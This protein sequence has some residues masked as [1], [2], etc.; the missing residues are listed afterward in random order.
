MIRTMGLRREGRNV[1]DDL[2]IGVA[3]ACAV[4]SGGQ[5]VGS[6]DVSNTA[7]ATVLVGTVVSSLLARLLRGR[8]YARAD[9]VLYLLLGLGAFFGARSLN[10]VFPLDTF[11]RELQPSSWLIWM[12]MFGSFVTWRDVTLLFQA[13]PALALFG[14]VGCYDTFRP[15]VFFFF[16]YLICIATLFARTH[17]R[18]M[19]ERAE[20]SGYFGADLPN[21]RASN[22]VTA[23]LRRGPWRWAAGPEWALGS[24]FAIV[25]V[26]LLGAPAVRQGVKPISGVA[27][28]NVTPTRRSS[29]SAVSGAP[30]TPQ[31][32][33]RIAQGPVRL[34]NTPAFD[35]T[36]SDE[37]YF[38]T[39]GFDQYRTGIW[40]KVWVWTDA[41]GN[42]AA[43]YPRR[44]GRSFTAG[45]GERLSFPDRDAGR[46]ASSPRE[47][48]AS[49]ER[50]ERG[51]RRMFVT[52]REAT[53]S[54]PVPGEYLDIEGPV[55]NRRDP[56]GGVA[57]AEARAYERLGVLYSPTPVVGRDATAGT[58]TAEETG[59]LQDPALSLEDAPPSV[60]AFA[61][62]AAGN[63]PDGARAERLRAAIAARIA[64]NIN[65]EAPPA[66]RDPVENA[67]FTT[68]EG[69]CDVFASAMVLG[70]RSLGI[71]A[72][73]ATGYV[74]DARNVASD[75][76]LVLLDSDS[77]AWAELYFAGI[78]WVPFDATAGARVVPGGDR[79]SGDPENRAFADLPIGTLVN[80]AIGALIV[81]GAALLLWPRR[82]T[83]RTEARARDLLVIRYVRALER[84]TRRTRRRD[85]TLG[86]FT[87]SAELGVT[88]DEA[89]AIAR[90]LERMLYAPPPAQAGPPDPGAVAALEKRVQSLRRELR[91]PSQPAR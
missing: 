47:E 75:G 73:Y 12:L 77:H 11:P 66:Q 53:T 88:S 45:D 35:V 71:P 49:R 36:V 30:T 89:R 1:V 69:Y 15:V 13:I 6:A 4:Y 29:T 74:A 2:L 76:T 3:S 32:T 83:S 17:A 21:L 56:G 7:L 26:S 41:Q 20:L 80:V 82:R 59:G 18:D 28:I 87:A 86:E 70:A 81:A 23:E 54:V 8:W 44:A 64:Y 31:S 78:G 24:A 63:G 34:K 50:S 85:E 14:F 67:L 61:R 68:H 33:A 72:R 42:A 57:L 22:T 65:A 43:P 38:R 16:V 58:L 48:P 10:L 52:A 62:K 39:N 79:R 55:Q 84:A 90:D 9:G 27:K 46:P 51:A 40:S 37:S 60:V 5:A 19:A 25:L 91:R